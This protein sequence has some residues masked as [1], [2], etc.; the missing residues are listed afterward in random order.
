MQSYFDRERLIGATEQ[1]YSHLQQARIEAIARS[2]PVYAQ[3]VVSGGTLN[4]GISQNEDCVPSQSNKTATD[5]CV[6]VVDSGDGST[7]ADVLDTTT[8]SADDLVMM[9][10][11]I[12]QFNGIS[13]ESGSVQ[14][15]FEPLRGVASTDTEIQLSS[16]PTFDRKLNINVGLLGQIS[17][18]SPDDSVMGYS[19]CGDD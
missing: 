11:D 14:I 17:I 5:A 8:A 4:Y 18:C 13:V 6:L 10:F 15:R 7:A 1:V 12:G 2:R 3:F 9:S 16:R 19:P